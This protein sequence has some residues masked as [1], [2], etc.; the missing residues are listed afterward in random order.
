MDKFIVK[1]P[2]G[3]AD[4][5]SGGS[6]L[7][8]SGNVYW[9]ITKAPLE[10]YCRAQMGGGGDMSAFYREATLA[11]VSFAKEIPGMTV[12]FAMGYIIATISMWWVTAGKKL[13]EEGN[14]S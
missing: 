6:H 4:G 14:A 11:A 5:A 12:D 3:K 7:D 8:E 1:D 13:M 2:S 10:A 9:E